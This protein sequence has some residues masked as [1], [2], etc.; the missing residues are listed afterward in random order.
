MQSLYQGHNTRT[1]KN[2]NKRF[3]SYRNQNSACNKLNSPKNTIKRD[4][5]PEN[6][7]SCDIPIP[8]NSLELLVPLQKSKNFNCRQTKNK[9][10]SSNNQCNSSSTTNNNSHLLASASAVSHHNNSSSNH[11]NS[12]KQQQSSQAEITQ[13][14]IQ[15]CPIPYNNQSSS[16]HLL[17]DF[18]NVL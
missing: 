1:R 17:K 9:S 4:V 3:G 12:N 8:T 16:S 15:N 10:S 11:S 13:N 14:L 2:D 5:V 6:T 18:E 7:Q